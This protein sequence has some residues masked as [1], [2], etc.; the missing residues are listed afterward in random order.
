MPYGKYKGKKVD[1]LPMSY[2]RWI[3]A[4]KFPEDIMAVARVK[5][6]A[7][8]SSKLMIDLTRHAI[9]SFSLRYLSV[10][11]KRWVTLKVQQG[12]A[13]FLAELALEAYDK[14]EDV[15]LT[16][17]QDEEVRKKFQDMIFVFNRDGEIK[18]LITVM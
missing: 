1:T 10:W 14:G 4:Q 16:R 15:S 17:H 2:L 7:N 12:I 11:Q 3:L 9:D 5:V 6:N 8:P 13:S 18:V